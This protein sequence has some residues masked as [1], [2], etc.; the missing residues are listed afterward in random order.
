MNGGGVVDVTVV[1]GDA[2][3]YYND[4]I[5]INGSVVP[6]HNRLVVIHHF[7]MSG[8]KWAQWHHVHVCLEAFKFDGSCVR[9]IVPSMGRVVGGDLS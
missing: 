5:S 4:H 7:G 2:L 9:S 3:E 6:I 1:G 8:L